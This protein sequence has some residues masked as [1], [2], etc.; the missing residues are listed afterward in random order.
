MMMSGVWVARQLALA[1]T[2]VI[3][4]ALRVAAVQAAFGVAASPVSEFETKA[5]YLFNFV[6]FTSWPS[7]ALPAGGSLQLCV[8]GAS[9]VMTSLVNVRDR[10]VD[11][12]TL[13]V[14][15]IVNPADLP[16]CHLVFVSQSES[17]RAVMVLNATKHAPALTVGE[18][19]D[20]LTHGGMITFVGQDNRVRFDINPAAAERVNLKISAHLLRLAR[21]TSDGMRP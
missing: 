11:G 14:T 4:A 5:A 6:K 13:A 21:Q 17:D 18:Q 16:R 7:A 8:V 9:E 19:A 12:H 1:M 15:R 10:V 3:A 2:I 20:F